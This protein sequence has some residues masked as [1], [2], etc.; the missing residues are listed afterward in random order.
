M[1]DDDKEKKKGFWS[2]TFNK[3]NVK[4][5]KVAIIYLRNN[6]VAEPMIVESKRGLFEINEKTY[7]EDSDCIYTI[8]KDR[9]PLAII[10]EWSMIPYGTKRW[11]DRDALEKFAECQDHVIRGI[12]RAE[13]VRMGE[14]D[15]GQINL[16]AIIIVGILVIIAL[17]FVLA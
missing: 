5:N 6:G 9:I 17:A 4:K 7:H 8:S 2:R 13:L 11:H 10:P 3:N 12:R 15:K 14:K 1:T 16:K